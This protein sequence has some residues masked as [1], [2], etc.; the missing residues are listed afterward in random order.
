[1]DAKRQEIH[2]SVAG[3]SE[4]KTSRV[5]KC[6]RNQLLSGKAFTSIELIFHAVVRNIRSRHFNANMANVFDI[7]QMAVV[8]TAYYFIL[9]FPGTYVA[10][11]RGEFV[12]YPSFGR[13]SVHHAYQIGRGDFQR[14]ERP[15]FQ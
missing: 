12:L 10:K 2:A 9:A 6:Q 14:R 3:Y 15:K 11:I 5:F 4:E 8:A 7:L 13:V 1:M